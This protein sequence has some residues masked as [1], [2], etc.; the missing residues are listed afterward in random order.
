MIATEYPIS[1]LLKLSIKLLSFD[2]ISF[3]PLAWRFPCHL[4][5]GLIARS[6]LHL[7]LRDNLYRVLFPWFGHGLYLIQGR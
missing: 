1:T 5:G 2:C 7:N 4:Q 3:Y 6:S